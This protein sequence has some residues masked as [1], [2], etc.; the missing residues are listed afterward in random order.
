MPSITVTQ[1]QVDGTDNA[2]LNPELA[3]KRFDGSSYT[4]GLI[5]G[6]FSVNNEVHTTGTVFK[7]DNEEYASA[8]PPINWKTSV[9]GSAG[10]ITLNRATAGVEVGDIILVGT[11]NY[12]GGSG[13]AYP[14]LTSGFTSITTGGYSTYFGYRWAYRIATSSDTSGSLTV[15]QGARTNS[16]AVF[17]ITGTNTPVIAGHSALHYPTDEAGP[18]SISSSANGI[19][20]AAGI[21]TSTYTTPDDYKYTDTGGTLRLIT[22]GSLAGQWVQDIP[23]TSAA[24]MFGYRGV[25]AG[26]TISNQSIKFPNPGFK[27]QLLIHFTRT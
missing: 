26:E 25:A 12:W 16:I 23:N 3:K 1:T 15:N 9:S 7:A 24:A 6:R 21:S 27:A 18:L 4:T 11:F 2:G 8:A 22:D 10:G 13:G 14:S 17:K 19:V 20:V 5:T